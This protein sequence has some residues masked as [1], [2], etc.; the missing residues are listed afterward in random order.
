MDKKKISQLLENFSRARV[1]VLGD[2]MLDEYIQGEVERIS[3]EAPIPVVNIS[4]S[5]DRD[6]RLGGA[7]NVFNNVLSLGCRSLYLCGVIGSDSEGRLITDR[8]TSQGCDTRGLITDRQRPT[9]LKTRIIS[10]NQQVIR[11]DREDRAALSRKTADAIISFVKRRIDDVDGIIISDY[12][13]GVVS[14]E[15]LEA[16]LPLARSKNKL[17]AV[18]P[19]FSNFRFFKNVTVM[20]PNR[21]EATGFVYY[22]ITDNGKAVAAANHILETLECDCVLIKLGERGMAF[23]DKAGKQFFIDTAAEQVFD[24]TGAGDTVIS[25]LVLARLSGASWREASL[26]ANI[27]AGVVIHYLGTTIITIEQLKHA[28]LK[29]QIRS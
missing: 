13:K 26:M 3:P 5:K 12:E 22:D 9:T 25:T 21:K 19:K 7:A 14:P 18:D 4:N 23:V 8:L 15:I 17:I 11:L 24:V 29:K 20:V 16:V 2:I 10:H 27:A 28:L 6:I 1:L